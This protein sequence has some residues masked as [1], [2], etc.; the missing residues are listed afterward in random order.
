MSYIGYYEPSYIEGD[1]YEFQSTPDDSLITITKQ[2]VLDNIDITNFVTNLDITKEVGRAFSVL[3]MTLKGYTLDPTYI[4][5]KDK[6][7]EVTIGTTTTNFII[8]DVDIDYKGTITLVGKTIGCLLDTPFSKQYDEVFLGNAN[9]LLE[10]FTVGV[11]TFIQTPTFDFFDGSFILKGSFLDGVNNLLAVSGGVL[12]E[13]YGSLFLEKA[14]TIGVEDEPTFIFNNNV[15]TNLTHSDN[16][17]GS[18]LV[19]AIVFNGS[20][21]DV[22]SKP[23][24][25]MVYNSESCERPYFLFNPI[26]VNLASDVISNLGNMSFTNKIVLFE[27][28]LDNASVITV[29]GG[30]LSIDYVTVGGVILD[31]SEYTFTDNYSSIVLTSNKTGVVSVSYRTRALS[32]YE[33]NG[34]FDFLNKSINYE[35]TYLTQKLDVEIDMC[36]KVVD[37]DGLNDFSIELVGE[38]ITKDTDTQFDVIGDVKSLALVSDKTTVPVTVNGYY[39]Y[40]A[41]DTTFM[42]T[43]SVQSDISVTKNFS[44]T[45]ED[46]TD[47]VEGTTEPVYGFFTTV[48]LEV[49]E[50]FVASVAVGFTKDDSNADYYIYYTTNDTLNG[51][52]VKCTYTA[53]VDRWTIPTVGVSNIVKHIDFY[54]EDNIHTFNY[55]NVDDGTYAGACILPVTQILDVSALLDI[56][57][58]SLSGQVLIYDE[59]NHT[60]NGIGEITIN[61]T[62]AEKIVIDTDFLRKGSSITI[63]SVNSG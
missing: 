52:G 22:S 62:K 11:P 13:Q 18:T 54:S 12:V 46:V 25:T 60:I 41:F 2:I 32:I 1:Y 56:K 33:K 45:I 19:D 7:L 59:V 21:S 23:L 9:E 61:I 27:G 51:R 10:E 34:K 55:P 6:L 17:D 43:I 49:D 15:L 26:S 58:S 24:I 57:P 14:L 44:T 48:G 20:D 42:N 8:F 4:R 40:G 28:T 3:S 31:V 5:N 47:N 30:I 50:A 39:A 36:V 38:R 35:L 53:L 16:F 37:G 29:S 63:D